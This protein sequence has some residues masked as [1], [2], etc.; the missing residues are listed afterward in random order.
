MDGMKGD[1]EVPKD[2]PVTGPERS[3]WLDIPFPSTLDKV[4]RAWDEAISRC[5]IA[6]EILEGRMYIDLFDDNVPDQ[7]EK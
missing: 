2:L 4:N 5:W 7:P 1:I 3:M 6:I